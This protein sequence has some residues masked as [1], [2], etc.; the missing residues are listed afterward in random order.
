MSAN[1]G[2]IHYCKDFRDF[3]VCADRGYC[4]CECGARAGFTL[5]EGAREWEKPID[6]KAEPTEIVQ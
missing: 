2:H 4:E 1:G 6:P 5:E 3:K